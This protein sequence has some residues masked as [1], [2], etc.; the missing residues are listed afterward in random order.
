[1]NNTVQTTTSTFLVVRLCVYT[2]NPKRKLFA[3]F[4]ENILKKHISTNAVIHDT[5]IVGHR[6]FTSHS[7][8]QTSNIRK[9][10]HH[11]RKKVIN[12]RKILTWL[13]VQLTSFHLWLS[14]QKFIIPSIP[15]QCCA[16]QGLFVSY[17]YFHLHKV[18]FS[19]KGLSVNVLP[20]SVI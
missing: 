9:T 16:Q 11:Q 17:M 4:S 1:M 20:N 14:S 5:R 13:P 18:L 8:Q 3:L 19:Q 12:K 2:F 6:T 10:R 15:T 7:N